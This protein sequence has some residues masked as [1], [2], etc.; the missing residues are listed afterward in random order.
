MY[1]KLPPL[2]LHVFSYFFFIS[3]VYSSGLNQF[4]GLLQLPLHMSYLSPGSLKLPFIVITRV[5]ALHKSG[6]VPSLFKILNH[7]S[8]VL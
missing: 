6:P 5:S 2:M 3:G 8:L 1:G 4:S 7:S